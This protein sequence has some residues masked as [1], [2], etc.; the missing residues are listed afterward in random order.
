MPSV[1]VEISV[2]TLLSGPHDESSLDCWHAVSCFWSIFLYFIMCVKGRKK[3]VTFWI[4]LSVSTHFTAVI[5]FSQRS[6]V[7]TNEPCKGGQAGLV[8]V[9]VRTGARCVWSHPAVLF[10]ISQ[11]RPAQKTWSTTQTKNEKHRLSHKV[12][13][14]DENTQIQKAGRNF[15]GTVFSTEH[16]PIMTSVKLGK[17]IQHLFPGLYNRCHE[18]Q[19]LMPHNQ[20]A[21]SNIQQR[22][23]RSAFV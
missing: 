22:P 14:Q 11:P 16:L 9:L 18:Y 7:L 23:S 13:A 5:F 17:Y 10:V 6:H 21:I 19:T 1:L 20:Q 12:H 8:I 4:C 2:L 3:T 15:F